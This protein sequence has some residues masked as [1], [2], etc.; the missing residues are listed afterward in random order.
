MKIFQIIRTSIRKKIWIL[1]SR[2]NLNQELELSIAE[3]NLKEFEFNEFDL[4]MNGITR[5]GGQP[6][7]SSNNTVFS[8]FSTKKYI[9]YKVNGCTFSIVLTDLAG[10]F[11]DWWRDTCDH[12]T[13]LGPLDQWFCPHQMH[14]ITP[15]PSPN[16]FHCWQG[17]HHSQQFL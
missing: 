6:D 13:W 9:L 10:T 7:Q 3:C 15:V 5:E 12:Q 11:Q 2:E 4:S 14:Y 1:T 16:G 8:T 17:V